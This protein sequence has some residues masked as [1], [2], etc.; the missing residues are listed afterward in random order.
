ESINMSQK[1]EFCRV[2]NSD[3]NFRDPKRENLKSFLLEFGIFAQISEIDI[4]NSEQK[5]GT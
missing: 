3:V 4:Y 2:M 5:E 1:K